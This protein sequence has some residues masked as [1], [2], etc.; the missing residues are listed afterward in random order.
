MDAIYLTPLTPLT[1]PRCNPHHIIERSNSVHHVVMSRVRRQAK[2]TQLKLAAGCHE[3]VLKGGGRGGRVALLLQRIWVFSAM[4]KQHIRLWGGLSGRDREHTSVLTSRCTIPSLC[5]SCNVD[6]SGATMW[7]ATK[8]SC[9]RPSC[10]IMSWYRSPCLR[11]QRERGS[12]WGAV[13]GGTS[14]QKRTSGRWKAP[15]RYACPL[16]FMH[17]SKTRYTWASSSNARS[18]FTTPLHL[19]TQ[20]QNNSVSPV[21]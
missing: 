11:Q 10:F 19:C 6:S 13:G 20:D 7:Q 17:G 3:A 5:N 21:A 14:R 16:T 1:P 15:Y 8:P 2:V 18:S 9:R 12:E 4:A